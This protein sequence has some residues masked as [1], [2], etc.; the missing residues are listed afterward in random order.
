MEGI[1]FIIRVKNEEDFL[2]ESLRSISG[3]NIPHDI[4]VILNMCT[5]RSRE[6]AES[7]QAEGMPIHIHTYDYQISRAGYELLVTDRD[8]NHSMTEYTR[9]C[10]SK[11]TFPWLFRWDADLLMTDPLRELLNTNSWTKPEQHSR[12]YLEARNSDSNSGEHHLFSVPYSVGKFIFW[13]TVNSVGDAVD[14]DTKGAH[15]MHLSN[16]KVKKSYWLEEP[17]FMNDSSEEAGII[18][19][20]F[21]FLNNICGPEAP[22]SARRANPENDQYYF[23]VRDKE[24]ELRENNIHFYT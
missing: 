8:S 15:M 5:D 7:L 11:A 24:T 12:Y 16:L 20:R 19:N 6:I 3:L 21:E 14:L 22:G 13:E 9:W 18:R 23:R 17:W 10:L 1:S 4:H 2:G